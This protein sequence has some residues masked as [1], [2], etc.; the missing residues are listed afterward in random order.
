MEDH[1]VKCVVGSELTKGDCQMP[2]RG[3][4]M[5]DKLQL[6]VP[7]SVVWVQCVAVLNN[8]SG[9]LLMEH[10]RMIQ[11][12]KSTTVHVILTVL[13]QLHHLFEKITSVSLEWPSG[14]YLFVSR[15]LT[16]LVPA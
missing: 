4:I 16:V 2:S 7:M 8:T 6:T 13:Y 11:D 5:T 9:H 12:T 10:G 14:L 3:I 1:T 15:G